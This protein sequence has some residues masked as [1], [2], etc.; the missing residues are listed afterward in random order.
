MH[1]T[2]RVALVSVAAAASAAADR[3][4]AACRHGVGDDAVASARGAYAARGQSESRRSEITDEQRS[5]G[6]CD[7]SDCPESRDLEGRARKR[8]TESK[9]E[10][11]REREGEEERERERERETGG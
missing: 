6:G 8:D 10:R 2:R 7:G 5:A 1:D 9:R 4:R 11:E 3:R